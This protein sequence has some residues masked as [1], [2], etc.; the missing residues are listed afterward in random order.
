MNVQLENDLF[1]ISPLV[2]QYLTLCPDDN[3][4]CKQDVE[5]IFESCGTC[6]IMSEQI[7]I[8]LSQLNLI[9]GNLDE[10]EQQMESMEKEDESELIESF[11]KLNSS[12]ME[13]KD[14][15]DHMIEQKE[16]T[17]SVEFSDSV[18]MFDDTKVCS[19]AIQT[20]QEVYDANQCVDREEC[21]AQLIGDASRTWENLYN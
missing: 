18:I 9:K 4:A 1:D 20:L 7:D 3:T 11:E 16:K 13:M 17:C 8:G 14:A 19:S 6:L 21:A 12:Y 2:N 5:H 15:L 10:F